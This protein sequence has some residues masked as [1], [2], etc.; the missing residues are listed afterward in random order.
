M[1]RRWYDLMMANQDDLARADDRGAG[2]A[3]RRVEGR[4]RLRGRLHRVVRGGRQAA[5]RGCDSGPSE[6]QA[7]PRPA[8]AHRGGRGDHAVEF[9]RGHDHP[10][11]RTRARR[12]LHLRLQAGAADSLLRARDG[13][14][15]RSRRRSRRRPQ[16]R[17][18]QQCRRDRRR[19][20]FQPH[21]AQADVHRL[22]AGRQAS[23][24]AMRGHAE[25]A[26]A[27]AR[28]Q[29]AI[30]RVRRCRPRCRGGGRSGEQVPQHRP[31]V[32]VRQPAARAERRVRGIH[33]QAGRRPSASCASA[34]GSKGRP[35]RGR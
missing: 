34:T 20:D 14:A 15:R 22:H 13:G 32:R 26:V 12:R 8:P 27:R 23:D 11:G 9:S 35:I 31:D 19:D 25:E 3:T 18:R 1:L 28:R 30:H 4:D 33:A 6:R 16:H 17:H 2:Q 21:R 29:C 24:G 5:L 10:Q 7:H